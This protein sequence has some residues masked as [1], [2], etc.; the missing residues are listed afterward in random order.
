MAKGKKT[1]IYVSDTYL[2]KI[3]A[4]P[5]SSKNIATA[6]NNLID[7]HYYVYR[8]ELRTVLS[9]FQKNELSLIKDICRNIEWHP[10]EKLH[11]G[12]LHQ[13]QFTD[14]KEFI[15]ENIS[16]QELE[17]KLRSLT[18]PQQFILVEALE[19]GSVCS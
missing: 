3:G 12:I 15:K 2:E 18:L 5:Y 4:E 14:E 13:I 17:D 1:S 11:D 7:R 16:K 8:L 6:R 19:R 10:A 9:K